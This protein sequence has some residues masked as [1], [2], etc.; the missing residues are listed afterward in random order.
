M[1]LSFSVVPTTG[2]LRLLLLCIVRREVFWLLSQC[3]FKETSSTPLEPQG[4]SIC[5]DMCA[6]DSKQLGYLFPHFTAAKMSKSSPRPH[7][8]YGA[9]VLPSVSLGIPNSLTYQDYPRS[10]SPRQMTAGLGVTHAATRTWSLLQIRQTNCHNGSNY[11]CC[12]KFSGNLLPVVYVS[13]PWDHSPVRGGYLDIPQEV[14]L[15]PI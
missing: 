12:T 7:I 1:I 15:Y 10:P 4:C 2:K 8:S 3:P 14:R 11:N 9:H 13:T 6:G 5:L